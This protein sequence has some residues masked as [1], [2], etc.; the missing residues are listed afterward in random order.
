MIQSD[1]QQWFF[2]CPLNYKHAK[3]KKIK[4]ATEFGF[5]KAT[6]KDRK[7]TITGT[8]KVIGIKKTLVYY[9]GRVAGDAK[10]TNWVIHEYHDVTFQDNQVC[11]CYKKGFKST[12]IVLV[13][14]TV[15]CFIKK[16]S[17]IGLSL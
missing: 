14:N 4:R 1:D 17:L 5:W 10:K 16:L 6:G 2:L 15:F 12:F 9:Q 8:N 11:F 3:S 13:C 7:I